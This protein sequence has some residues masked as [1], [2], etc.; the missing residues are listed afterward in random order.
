MS[1]DHKEKVLKNEKWDK[2]MLW[3]VDSWFRWMAWEGKIIFH[4]WNEQKYLLTEVTIGLRYVRW[5]FN[6]AKWYGRIFFN[7]EIYQFFR[8]NYRKLL[9][10]ISDTNKRTFKIQ[11]EKPQRSNKNHFINRGWK[12]IK[13]Q[14]TFDLMIFTQFSL[15]FSFKN[16][17]LFKEMSSK[18][19]KFMLKRPK[20]LL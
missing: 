20:E 5:Q 11:V 19:S 17:L 18:L 7:F 12:T 16:R 8:D 6:I 13:Y 14:V 4:G 9:F 2:S 15:T 10:N 3:N 1:F